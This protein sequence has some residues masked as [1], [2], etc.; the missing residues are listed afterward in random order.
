MFSARKHSKTDSEGSIDSDSDYSLS[1]SEPVDD[2][3]AYESDLNSDSESLDESEPRE[4]GFG[5]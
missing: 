1:S 5:K 2:E 3:S 4:R